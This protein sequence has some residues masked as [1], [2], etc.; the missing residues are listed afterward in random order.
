[1]QSDIYDNSG[2]K[3]VSRTDKAKGAF[4]LNAEQVAAVRAAGIVPATVRPYP[5]HRVDVLDDPALTSELATIY[6]SQRASSAGRVPEPRMG[7][8]LVSSWMQVGDRIILGNIGSKLF[9]SKAGTSV[10][11]TGPTAASLAD[12]LPRAEIFARARRARGRPARRE[13]SRSDFV[14]NPFVVAAALLRSHRRCELP[15]CTRRLFKRDDGSSY[16]EVHHVV[17]LSE[18]GTDTLSN[19]A[20]L[21]PSCHREQHSGRNR[22]EVRSTLQAYIATAPTR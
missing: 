10:D 12:A 22:A 18:G 17:P 21:C 7:L 3:A 16:V 1:M 15:G 4:V 8:K 2:I 9:I 6:L 19:V 13:V 5:S 14:R 20:A 11:V